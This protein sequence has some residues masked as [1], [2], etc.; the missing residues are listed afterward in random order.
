MKLILYIGHHKVGSTALQAFL[1][2]NSHA[3][4]AAGILHPMVDNRGLVHLLRQSIGLKDK[5]ASLPPHL[6]EPHSALAYR[7]LETLSRGTLPPQ[8]EGMPSLSAMEETVRLQI[9]RTEPHTVIL[10]SEVFSTF[11]ETDGT[12]IKRLL[13]LFPDVAEIQ[14]YGVLR[15]PDHYLVS[16]HGQRLKVGEKIPAIADAL[17]TYEG[18]VHLDYARAVRPWLEHCP[19]ASVT[20]RNYADVLKTGNSVRDFRKHAKVKWPP[21]LVPPPRINLSLPLPTMEIVRRGNQ[22]LS[23]PYADQLRT[24]LMAQRKTLDLVPGDQV[25]MLGPV[26]R[27]ELLRLFTPVQAYLNN[28]TGREAFFPDLERIADCPKVPMHQAVRSV[29]AQIGPG[30][31]GA[32]LPLP[33][34]RFIAD[35]RQEYD[36]E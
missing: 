5:P 3:L 34:L 32:D 25:D 27:S 4:S 7:I 12:A 35:L 29:L 11:G 21:D 22:T 14:I 17:A 2:Q 6:R 1:T 31:R 16:W 10:C 24:F 19:Q 28:V 8:F 18:T 33:V 23:P 30:K 13:A 26:T 9:D 15:R 36:L 20:L